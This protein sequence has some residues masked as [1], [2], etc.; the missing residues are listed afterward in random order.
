MITLSLVLILAQ[1]DAPTEAYRTV[2]P[3]S[4]N[5]IQKTEIDFAGRVEKL[6]RQNRCTIVVEGEPLPPLFSPTPFSQQDQIKATAALFDYDSRRTEAKIFLWRKRYSAP[7]D[8]PSFSAAEA[9]HVMRSTETV[10]RPLLSRSFQDKNHD[11]AD[12]VAYTLTPGQW[13]QM[14]SAGLPVASLTADQQAGIYRY[15]RGLAFDFMA[16]SEVQGV[17]GWVDRL[18]KKTG[19]IVKSGNGPTARVPIFRVSSG[20]APGYPQ[21]IDL[22]LGESPTNIGQDY[23]GNVVVGSNPTALSKPSEVRDNLRPTE[24]DIERTRNYTPLTTLRTLA[25]VVEQQNRREITAWRYAVDTSLASK[26]VQVFGEEFAKSE[27]I[28]RACGT[29]YGLRVVTDKEAKTITLTYPTAQP[30]MTMESIASG[31]TRIIPEPIARWLRMRER[32][33]VSK[34]IIAYNERFQ[35]WQEW[36]EKNGRT[37]EDPYSDGYST[38]LPAPWDKAAVKVWQDENSAHWKEWAKCNLETPPLALRR[39]RASCEPR[40]DASALRSIPT[41]ELTERESNDLAAY[42]L[43]SFWAG[44]GYTL[45]SNTQPDYIRDLK[46]AYLVGELRHFTET[47]KE[48]AVQ[49]SL[50]INFRKKD[51]TFDEKA[52]SAGIGL[53]QPERLSIK[54]PPPIKPDY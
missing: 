22:W 17:V 33:Q 39:F 18:A 25:N 15:F 10:V 45:A 53:S 28:I 19:W 13:E 26:S 14:K 31:L 35:R 1:L 3:R 7:E 30:A 9:A 20:S 52:G 51:G 12:S 32:A 54:P 36:R 41:S 38:T 43:C 16:Y 48:W 34:D 44:T 4:S 29:V 37:A 49:T 40:L 47:S 46:K 2:L 21:F 42:F 6:S 23:S 11:F 24:A 50:G 8:I 5:S 27:E